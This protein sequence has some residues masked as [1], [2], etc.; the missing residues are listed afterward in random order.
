MSKPRERQLFDTTL[1]CMGQGLTLSQLVVWVHNVSLLRHFQHADG[2]HRYC[3]F[4]EHRGKYWILS[5]DVSS[6]IT[7]LVMLC[8]RRKL[9]GRQVS[10][11]RSVHAA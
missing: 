1:G 9:I 2:G 10:T 11:D 7:S 6:L 5:I 3:R 8:V 4:G